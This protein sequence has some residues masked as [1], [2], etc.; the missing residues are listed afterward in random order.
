MTF[1]SDS[2]TVQD[3]LAMVSALIAKLGLPKASGYDCHE[4]AAPAVAVLFG[5]PDVHMCAEHILE[6]EP[7]I[8]TGDDW[9]P[10][11]NVFDDDEWALGVAL[12]QTV[13][14][15]YSEGR[16]QCEYC[17]RILV[18]GDGG[19]LTHLAYDCPKGKAAATARLA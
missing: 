5:E 2:K 18:K 4:C 7:S 12:G 17:W 1:P 14:Q 6:G 10:W 3:A 8:W 15:W 16:I 11:P 19:W 9:E 13:R